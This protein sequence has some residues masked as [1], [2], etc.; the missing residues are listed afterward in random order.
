M[1]RI[2]YNTSLQTPR[3]TVVIP[4]LGNDATLWECVSSLMA[5][6]M[7]DIE[8]VIVDNS[9]SGAVTRSRPQNV[10]VNILEMPA[11]IGF[12]GAVNAGFAK[13]NAPFL[14]TI[15][16]D[17]M[18]SPTW[19]ENLLTAI[20]S[21]PGI[22]SCASAV[23]LMGT[24]SLD[25]AGMLIAADGSSK[26]R[27]NGQPHSIFAKPEMVLMASGS[28]SFF[29]REMIEQTG[30]FDEDFFLYCE[31]SDLGLR[32]QWAGWTCAY[33][34]QAL[35]IHRYSQSAGKASPLKAYLVERNRLRLIVKNFP[36]LELLITPFA[37]LLRYYW[38]IHDLAVGSGKASQFRQGGNSPLFL[39]WLVVKAHL[40][41]FPALPN[42]IKKR[43]QVRRSARISTSQFRTLLHRHSIS[44][45]QV[46]EQ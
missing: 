25:S 45:R 24:N 27:G 36:L 42:L 40:A 35:V 1:N 29:R 44:L 9:G 16:D 26:Q 5:Q 3:V 38:H 21:D 17:A 30:G 10:S 2:A 32:A 12:G 22:G 23:L 41:I 37:A 20:E 13:S 8:V 6:T 7:T 15:N 4:T 34:P 46:T 18:A 19:L 33:V 31:D 39:I 28:A 11:N 43:A 14:A